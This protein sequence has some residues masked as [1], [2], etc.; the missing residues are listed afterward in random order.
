MFDQTNDLIYHNFN[1]AMREK[2][3]KQAYDLG[4]LDEE[5]VVSSAAKH[6]KQ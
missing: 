5:S 6:R 3:S 2:M 1:E 4:L